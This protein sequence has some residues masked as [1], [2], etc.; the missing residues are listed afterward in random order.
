MP[1]VTPRALNPL[2]AGGARFVLSAKVWM[3]RF[4]RFGCASELANRPSAINALAESLRDVRIHPMRL[5]FAVLVSLFAYAPLAAQEQGDSAWQYFLAW[6][7]SVSTAAFKDVDQVNYRWSFMPSAD[8][9]AVDSVAVADAFEV[10][11]LR[12]FS[13]LQPQRW[14]DHEWSQRDTTYVASVIL[15]LW[16]I[17]KSPAAY[18]IKIDC[19]TV[20]EHQYIFGS[21]EYLGIGGPSNLRR[22]VTDAVESLVQGCA[23]DFYR[24]R[25]RR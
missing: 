12:L 19:Q 5:R 1:G 25:S 3:R 21:N 15:R 23:V 24:K 7:D 9:L 13:D 10:T 17:G 14:E 4:V 8:S 11:V 16:T 2:F 18:H 6:N 20:D 22:S